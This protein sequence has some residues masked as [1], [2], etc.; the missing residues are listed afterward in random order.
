V[1][2]SQDGGR[3]SA[4]R[5]GR[6][7]PQHIL[8]FLI[9]VRGWV[10]P[11]ATVQSEGFFVNENPLKPAG[12]FKYTNVWSP[13]LI[14]WKVSSLISP[15]CIIYNI[16]IAMSE[17]SWRCFYSLIA[18]VSRSTLGHL[19]FLQPNAAFLASDTH[20]TLT[21][22]RS[23]SSRW[24]FGNVFSSY[25]MSRNVLVDTM[26]LCVFAGAID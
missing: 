16:F 1:T 18:C 13:Q 20:S 23:P 15:D 14:N 22:L 12:I 11:R 6:F 24:G 3:L 9:S 25:W 17:S 5:N 7:Y 19:E 2:T 26:S 8:L 21:Y 10:D 4:L